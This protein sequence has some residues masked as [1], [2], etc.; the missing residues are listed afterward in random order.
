MSIAE[1]PRA[2]A[3]PQS[4]QS[5]T[6]RL[7]IQA[8]QAGPA[9]RQHLIDEVI[10]ANIEVARS[11]ARRYRNRGIATEDLE[12]V[13]CVALVRAAN[14]FD[15]S[16]ADDFLAY[17]V[18]SIRGE[19]RRHF[20]DHGWT[21]RPPRGIQE[22]QAAIGQ[23]A[24]RSAHELS[25]AE[26]ADELDVSLDEV[27]A[28]RAAN[29]CFA[30][31]SLDV[32][33]R[34]GGDSL[35]STL[36]DIEFDEHAAVEARV[37]LRTLTRELKPRERLILYLRFVEGRTQSEIGEELGVSQMHVSRLLARTL[38]KMRER[39]LAAGADIDVA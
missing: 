3:A 18:P 16:K 14:K 23:L 26:V 39:A 7:L 36:V 13:A 15:P 29:G 30:A 1:A 12:Q 6:N 24:S 4:R 19:V 9:E 20:R 33:V 11:I 32:P 22:L 37:I 38:E 27:R 8:Q 2:S 10:V 28:A 31:T 25:D 17:A 5:T 34:D 35:G 21:V